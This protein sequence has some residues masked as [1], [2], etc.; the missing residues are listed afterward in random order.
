[1]SFVNSAIFDITSGSSVATT[2]SAGAGSNRI[3]GIILSHEQANTT[4]P[5]TA[6][7]LGGANATYLGAVNNGTS[8]TSYVEF[9]YILEANISSIGSN[10]TMS[11][12]IT[13]GG[14]NI[15]SGLIFTAD[16]VDQTAAN[17]TTGS[18]V[19]YADAA[20]S[21]SLTTA[22]GWLVVGGMTASNGGSGFTISAPASSE[23]TSPATDRNFNGTTTRTVNF[24]ATA[25]GSSTTI[26][27]DS[28][29]TTGSVSQVIFAAGLPTAPAGPTISG[30]SDD[31]PAD[32]STLTING[33]GFGASQGTGGVTAGGTGWT[34][35]SW[36]DTAIQVTVA[37]GNN[38]YNTNVSLVVTDNSSNASSGYNVQIQPASGKSYVNLSG[39]LATE[40][41]RITA[42][43]DL[44]SGDQLEISNVIGGTISD[45][46][47]NADASFSVVAGVTAFDVRVNDDTGW[48][49]AA[50]QYVAEPGTD[51]NSKRGLVRALVRPLTFD[52][53]RDISA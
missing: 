19:G 24:Q 37:L 9:W 3:V 41:D 14:S 8:G 16:N 49:V 33:S 45:V 38:K 11:A 34:E 53:A 46:T 29:L 12:T 44:A 2:Y 47:V 48:S 7:S 32:G 22:S 43:P 51:A 1:M 21:G 20:V 26:T 17:W 30:T 36:S 40:G 23:I 52:I 10:P 25:S 50:T 27:G 13:A 6:V 31:T 18:A 35:T 39:T 4:R 42:I 28:G 5:L 15:V